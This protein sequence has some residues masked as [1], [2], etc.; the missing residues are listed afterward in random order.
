MTPSNIDNLVLAIAV[1]L[2]SAIAMWG[3]RRRNDL[4]E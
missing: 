2:L 4:D 1:V 3:Y